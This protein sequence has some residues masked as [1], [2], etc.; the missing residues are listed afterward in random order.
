MRP[1][2]LAAVVTFAFATTILAQGGNPP[3]PANDDSVKKAVPGQGV[4]KLSRRER[5][6]QLEKL[7]ITYRDFL[8]DVEPIMLPA[9]VET[10]LMLETDAQRDSF[11]D[12][13]WR[14]RDTL[15][16][17]TNRAF[18]D[19]YYQRLAVAKEQFKKAASD[20]AKMFLL[21]GP[22]GEIVRAECQRLLQPIEVWKY[23]QIAGM[24]H[25]VRLLFYKP[26]NGNDYRLWNPIGGTMALS[27]LLS[28][29]S[30]ASSM[31]GDAATRRVFEQSASPYSYLN[32][33]QL[34]C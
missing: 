13:F 23:E 3:A 19:T 7:A 25:G 20:R 12:D 8:E 26:R 17:T 21:H 9:E 18:R 1:S 4:R 29:D 22:P 33:I 16:G 14:R 28:H 27:E 30:M 11:V 32:R 24:G 15:Q 2:A 31:G 6:E 10:F 34:D 5:K